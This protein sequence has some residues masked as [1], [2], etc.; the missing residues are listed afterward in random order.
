M[1]CRC[2]DGR[3]E[4]GLEMAAAQFHLPPIPI[5]PA[6]EI[7]HRALPFCPGAGLAGQLFGPLELVQCVRLLP[8]PEIEECQIHQTLDLDTR[9]SGDRYQPPELVYGCRI[10]FL[11]GVNVGDRNRRDK[12][13]GFNG[14]RF[15]EFFYRP[16]KVA[17]LVICASDRVQRV[18]VA[19]RDRGISLV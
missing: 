6:L 1:A 2:A 15:A 4:P 14:E 11:Q 17:H 19:G 5:E 10:I 9:R 8:Q 12:E 7:V 13:I 3:V 16:V 18:G